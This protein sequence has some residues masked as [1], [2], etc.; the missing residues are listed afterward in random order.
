[1]P[2]A[3]GLDF[4]YPWWLSYGHLTILLCLLALLAA[5]RIR[6][7]SRVRMWTLGALAAWAAVSSIIVSRFDVNGVPS[8]PAPNFLSSGEG[9]VLDIGAGTGRS[10]VMVLRARPRATLVALDLFGDSFARHFGPGTSPQARLQAN[11]QAAGV[12]G[13]AAIE[14]AD[15]R[16]LPFSAA[17]FDAAVS[18]YAMDHLSSEGTVQ[19]LAEAARVIRPGG[20]FLLILVRND[21]LMKVAFGPLLSHGG[22]RGKEWWTARLE[23]SGFRIA[24][25]G[26][27]PATMF[28]LLHK[29][30]G[31]R[32]SS[33][34]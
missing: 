5:G 29:P 20:E 9:R 31:P 24:E 26:V 12:A 17:S 22:L 7:W 25:T 18:A 23:E 33:N 6:A 14:T 10:S 16:K 28:F 4:G 21:W 32:A 2:A 27:A 15:M 19:A 1:M 30:A 3:A 13:R 11:L 34:P 8:L